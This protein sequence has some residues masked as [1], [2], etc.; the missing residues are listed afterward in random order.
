MCI[1]LYFLVGAGT[2]AA[3][4]VS[5]LSCCYRYISEDFGG[6]AL[7]PVDLIDVGSGRAAAQLTDPNVATICTGKTHTTLRVLLLGASLNLKCLW[8]SRSS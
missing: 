8:G 6:V 2:P 4:W 5:G 7:H 1:Q 3:R